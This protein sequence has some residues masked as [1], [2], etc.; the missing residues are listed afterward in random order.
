M[1][2]AKVLTLDIENTAM[3]IEAW[4]AWQQ[5]AVR[6][7]KPTIVLCVGAKWMHEEKPFVYAID[8]KKKKLSDKEV[9]KKIWKDLDEA[10]AVITHN[11]D[12]HDLKILNARFFYHRLGMPSPYISIDTKKLAKKVGRFPTNKLKHIREFSGHTL[13]EDSGGYGTWERCLEWHG[14]SW[15]HLTEYCMNDV[16][17]TEETYL[18]LRPYAPPHY[19]FSAFLE[20]NGCPSCGSVQIQKRGHSYS[21]TGKRERIQCMK[22]GAWSSGKHEKLVDIK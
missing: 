16:V 9:C 17:A 3:V 11:G 2:Q 8:W 14:P 18:E 21:K 15:K 6:I 22:C 12:Q 10:D 19:N 5:D 4:G 20:R 13:K 1:R 7:L